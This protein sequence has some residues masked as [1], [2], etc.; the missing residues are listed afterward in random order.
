MQLKEVLLF[1]SCYQCCSTWLLPDTVLAVYLEDAWIGVDY[2]G[3]QETIHTPDEKGNQ[4]I[5]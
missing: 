3:I 5:P 1:R 4:N 2:E